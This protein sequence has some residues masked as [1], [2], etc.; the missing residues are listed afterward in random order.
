MIPSIRHSGKGK[1]YRDRNQ[2]GREGD[3]LQ[4]GIK[5]FR[6]DGHVLDLKCNGGHATVCIHQNS[7]NCISEKEEIH[8]CKLYLN[9][10]DLKGKKK[11]ARGQ[12]SLRG[13]EPSWQHGGEQPLTHTNAQGCHRREKEMLPCWVQA[14]VYLIP[15]FRPPWHS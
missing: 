2:W 8:I 10:P 9:K 6:T 1:I 13:R 15:Q 11:P 5:C 12:Q 7:L 3:Q 14:C 4:S